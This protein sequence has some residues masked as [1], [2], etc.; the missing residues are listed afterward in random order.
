M[1][2]SANRVR[3]GCAGLAAAGAAAGGWA[4]AMAPRYTAT[5]TVPIP[6]RIPMILF[7]V[8]FSS[9]RSVDATNPGPATGHF[10]DRGHYETPSRSPDRERSVV[11]SRFEEVKA[12]QIVVSGEWGG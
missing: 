10:I 1:L 3:S 11:L 12:N 5:P 2:I 7:T 6:A 4:H 9:L 8:R